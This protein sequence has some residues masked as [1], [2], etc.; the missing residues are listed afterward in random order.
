MVAVVVAGAVISGCGGPLQAGTAVF[1]GDDA[2]PLERIQSQV[3]SF[4][5]KA[6]GAD[7]FR[8]Q[9]GDTAQLSRSVVAIEVLHS[10]LSRKADELGI[11]VTDSQ[12]DAEL[13]ARGGAEAILAQ[14]GLDLPTLRTQMRDSLL[15][16]QVGQRVAPTLAVTVELVGVGTSRAEAERAAQVLAA[17]G[18]EAEALMAGATARRVV[19]QAGSFPSG[20]ASVLLGLPAGTAGAFQPSPNE[21]GWNAFRIVERRTDVPADP[22]V[23]AVSEQQASQIGIREAQLSGELAGIR[24]NPRYGE[25]DSVQGRVVPD[26]QQVGE[27]ILPDPASAA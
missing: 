3:G 11:V 17:G 12:V 22:T 5:D 13:A 27:I 21:A 9:G 7:S 20:L 14:S 23:P 26:G 24:V 19:F 10:L 1:V 2:V 8:A 6:G 15:S 4:L 25:W 18:P 16:V